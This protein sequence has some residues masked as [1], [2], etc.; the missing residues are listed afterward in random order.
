MKISPRTHARLLGVSRP[1]SSVKTLFRL[2]HCIS[3]LLFALAIICSSAALAHAASGDLDNTFGSGGK[4]TAHFEVMANGDFINVDSVISDT[5]LQPDGKILV[6]GS[7]GNY[8]GLARYQSDGVPDAAFGDG[9]VVKTPLP[10]IPGYYVGGAS[11]IALQRD[12]KI[13]LA[14]ISISESDIDF[15]VARYNNDGS[16]DT[17][18]GD[19]GWVITD[20]FGEYDMAHDIAIQAD[21]KIV[22]AGSANKSNG[23]R[24]FMALARYNTDGSLDAGFGIGGKSTTESCPFYLTANAMAIQ[25]DGKIVLA[26]NAQMITFSNFAVAR[27]NTDGNLERTFG[28]GGVMSTDFMGGH[29]EAA[30]L[31]LQPDGKIVLAGFASNRSGSTSDFAVARY[32]SNGHLD[33]DFGTNGRAVADFFGD[34]EIGNAMAL[35]PDGRIVL[36]GYALISENNSDFATAVFTSGGELDTT[37]GQSG[38]TTTDFYGFADNPMAIS[39]QPDGKFIVSG[40]TSGANSLDFALARYTW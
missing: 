39:V 16:L 20:F 8:F 40:Y 36:V 2:S 1:A 21:G 29:D 6:A 11:A 26:G 13:V 28:S 18:F 14:G 5:T 32:N 38:R 35:L 9:G 3:A 17:S 33:R 34:F 30:D 25:P 10:G 22:V 15:A 23:T 7:I 19:A 24:S 31:A 27:F 4:V 12:G 37:F